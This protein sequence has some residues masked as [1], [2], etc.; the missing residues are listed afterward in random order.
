MTTITDI[1][2]FWF[3]DG[4]NTKRMIWFQVNPN[5]D[6][7]CRDLCGALLTPARDNTFDHWAATPDGA[8]A[9]MLLLD[10]MPRNIHR[11]TALAFASDEKARATAR[12]YIARGIDRELT[13]VQRGFIYLPFEHAENLEDQDI[14]VRL[15]TALCAGPC[16]ENPERTIDF[17]HRHHDVIRRFGRFPHRNAALGR[18]STIAEADYL[19]RPNA[20]F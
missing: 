16:V 7:A 18:T 17:V 2:D 20:G 10:Q 4:P 11:G 12:D 8:L 14:S 19:T 1:L 13:Q 5:F 9:L 6:A 3:A 15:F